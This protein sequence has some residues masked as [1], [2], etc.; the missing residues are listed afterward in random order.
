MSLD[1]PS[2][3]EQD[4]YP[5]LPMLLRKAWERRVSIRMVALRLT[6][7]YG[8]IFRSELALDEQSRKRENERRLAGVLDQSARRTLD[9]ARARPVA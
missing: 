1:E 9:H 4:I 8:G 5:L 7:I 3:L 6:G 2:D